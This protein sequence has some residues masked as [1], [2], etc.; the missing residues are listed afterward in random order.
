MAVSG[1]AAPVATVTDGRANTDTVQRCL[2]VPAGCRSDTLTDTCSD[3]TSL[4]TE[5][6]RVHASVTQLATA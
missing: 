3:D 1:A 6:K 5:R 2:P 4:N